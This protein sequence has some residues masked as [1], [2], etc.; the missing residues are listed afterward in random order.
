MIPIFFAVLL[1]IYGAFGG[2]SLGLV[3][4]QLYPVLGWWPLLLSVILGPFAGWIYQRRAKRLEFVELRLVSCSLTQGSFLR[5]RAHRDELIAM[6]L[7]LAKSL[8]LK[9]DGSLLASPI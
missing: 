4:A 3:I 1:S 2:G 9:S 7:E 5:L 6:E 8:Q